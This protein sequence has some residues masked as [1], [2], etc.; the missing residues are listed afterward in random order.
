MQGTGRGA[1][2]AATKTIV[3][4]YEMWVTFSWVLL[5]EFMHF[6]TVPY[7]VL[8]YAILYFTLCPL[9]NRFEMLWT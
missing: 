9:T 6:G 8:F 1:E 3:C 5:T 7:S 2:L 4:M